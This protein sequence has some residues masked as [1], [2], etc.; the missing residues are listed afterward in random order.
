M[1]IDG[2]V[3][4]G[5]GGQ[6]EKLVVREEVAKR[7]WKAA[8]RRWFK[9]QDAGTWPVIRAPVRPFPMSGL[10]SAPAAAP[11][12]ALAASPA[13]VSRALAAQRLRQKHAA[14]QAAL[15]APGKPAAALMQTA[16]AA[17]RGGA[18]AARGGAVAAARGAAMARLEEAHS[19]LAAAGAAGGSAASGQRLA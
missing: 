19:Q 2:D 9:L 5:R 13:P 11:H 16:L 10:A 7:A 15:V 3:H 18:V 4:R 12:A 8:H 14:A 1:H 17:A 6:V